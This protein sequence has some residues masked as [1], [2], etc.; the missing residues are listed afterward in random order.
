MKPPLRILISTGIYPPQ[1]GGPAQYAK[2]LKISLEK[3]GHNVFVATYYFE[4]YLPSG[5]RHL[6]FFLKIIPK[7]I[8]SD[9]VFV[10]DT[11]SVGLPSVLACKIFGK[12]SIIRT[13]G[14]F[15]W[16]KYVERTGKKVFLRDFYESEKNNF[17]IKE[18]IIFCLIKWTLHNASHVIFSTEWQRNIFIKTYRLD[19]KN[20][21]VIENYYGQKEGEFDYK[22][23]CFVASGRKLVLKNLNLLQEVFDE[24]KKKD[25]TASLFLGNLP[26]IDFVEKIKN[27]YAVIQVSLS[28]ISPNL[29][30]DAIRY[31][32]PFICTKEVGIYEKI[33]D[34]GIFVDPLNKKEIEDAI[35]RLLDKDGYEKA[36]EKVR[37]FTFTHTWEDIANEFLNVFENLKLKI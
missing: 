16:E 1:I 22:E 14:A 8:K 18:R 2:N 30:L 35:L 26:F 32:K 27:S 9:T 3:M 12:K 11:F 4:N 29:I 33:K 24:I 10:L 20:I 34:A 15:L 36:K 21:S 23:K 25:N 37:Q 7:V 13:G 5:I 6:Y 31:N 28:D 17:T 19:I